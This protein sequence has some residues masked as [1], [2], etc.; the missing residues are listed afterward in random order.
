MVPLRHANA[1]C[2]KT[3]IRVSLARIVADGSPSVR[4]I[5]AI[6]ANSRSRR[7][8]SFVG[9]GL[10]RPFAVRRVKELNNVWG[11]RRRWRAIFQ[12][13][14]ASESELW[15]VCW[16]RATFSCCSCIVSANAPMSITEFREVRRGGICQ[17]ASSAKVTG[18]NS[19]IA[20]ALI[21]FS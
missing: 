11:W 13:G 10:I 19:L 18:R 3:N 1:D 6:S 20:I 9:C 7:R 5:D 15:S 16:S 21:D 12:N 14:D 4:T 17:S 8:I 2:A